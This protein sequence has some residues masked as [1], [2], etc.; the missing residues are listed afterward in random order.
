MLISI[1]SADECV[2][3]DIAIPFILYFYFSFAG[4][5]FGYAIKYNI[6]R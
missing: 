5:D 4:D 2:R 6:N 3:L 1:K